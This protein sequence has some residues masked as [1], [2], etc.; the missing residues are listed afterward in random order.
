MN[1]SLSSCVDSKRTGFNKSKSEEKGKSRNV[2]CFLCVPSFH[3]LSVDL[4]QENI[5]W[6]VH[7]NFLRMVDSFCRFSPHM[8]VEGNCTNRYNKSIKNTFSRLFL[9]FAYAST[10]KLYSFLFHK[11]YI[12][13][14]ARYRRRRA[15]SRRYQPYTGRCLHDFDPPSRVLTSNFHLGGIANANSR[16]WQ[17]C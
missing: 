12:K 4:K 8:Y 9:Y 14:L 7:F 5:K 10:D 15:P 6:H 13:L 1:S 2:F 11:T 16:L 17:E 3:R